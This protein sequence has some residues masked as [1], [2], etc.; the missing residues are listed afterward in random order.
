MVPLTGLCVREG[1]PADLIFVCLFLAAPSTDPR[2]PA[3]DNVQRWP[4][5]LA[6][7]HGQGACR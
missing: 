4:H 2:G 7:G 5:P 1:S 6:L 3:T